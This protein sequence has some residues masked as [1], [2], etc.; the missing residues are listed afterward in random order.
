MANQISKTLAT[1]AVGGLVVGL[2][3]CGGGT[4]P[5]DGAGDAPKGTEAASCKGATDG[6][7]G[8]HSCKAGACKGNKEEAA[9]PAT[10]PAAAPK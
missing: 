8:A 3:A 5:A 9:P 1:L 7:G 6:A 10:D 2:A 4:P